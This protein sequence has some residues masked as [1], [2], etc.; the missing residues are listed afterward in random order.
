MMCNH[1]VE[2]Q[3]QL[4]FVCRKAEIANTVHIHIGCVT[5]NKYKGYSKRSR[6]Y[7]TREAVPKEAPMHLHLNQLSKLCLN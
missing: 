7:R 6:V 4:K 5:D 1:F 2:E 3:A